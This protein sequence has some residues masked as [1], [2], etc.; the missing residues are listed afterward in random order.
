MLDS[1]AMQQVGTRPEHPGLG[2]LTDRE[3]DAWMLDHLSTALHTCGTTPM[4]TDPSASVVDG[5][6]AVHGVEGLII[7]DLGIVPSTP[8][9]GPAATAVL[10]GEVIADALT[11]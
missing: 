9:G 11:S 10:I 2:H 7:A 4:G 5:R 6:G 1:D 8:T 3:L